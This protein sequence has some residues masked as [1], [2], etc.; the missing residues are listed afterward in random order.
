MKSQMNRMFATNSTPHHIYERAKIEAMHAH[1]RTHIIPLARITHSLAHL[2]EWS[3]LHETIYPLKNCV[4]L[5]SQT[6]HIHIYYK[7]KVNLFVLNG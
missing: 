5:L 7:V 2:L 4:R 1:T 6:V 3:I